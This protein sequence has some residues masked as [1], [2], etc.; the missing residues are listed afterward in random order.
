MTL[1]RGP[2]E[3]YFILVCM[4]FVLT[5]LGVAKVQAETRGF[6]I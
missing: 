2:L 4:I 3:F 5:C 1:K 6:I